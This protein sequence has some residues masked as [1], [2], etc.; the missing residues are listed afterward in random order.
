[1]A[2]RA[3]FH[4]EPSLEGGSQSY[5]STLVFAQE[6]IVRLAEL[7][8]D[9]SSDDEAVVT[10]L[11]GFS[12]LSCFVALS[13]P[14]GKRTGPF[15]AHFGRW[16]A[17]RTDPLVVLLINGGE[18][19]SQIYPEDDQSLA[20]AVRA[21]GENARG[22]SQFIHGWRGYEDPRVNEFLAEHPPSA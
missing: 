11:C 6:H 8:P 18:I 4:D 3:G 9:V 2:A 10:S 15:L 19:R 17:Q 12:L 1:M 16:L 7:R 14:G 5:K 13:V 22:M 21:V 20:D